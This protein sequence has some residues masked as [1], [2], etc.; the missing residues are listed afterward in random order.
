MARNALEEPIPELTDSE[1]LTL[2]CDGEEAEQT[3]HRLPPGCGRSPRLPANCRIACRCGTFPTSASICTR[4]QHEQPHRYRIRH[5]TAYTYASDVVHSHQLLH[6]VPRP[7][8]YQQC[9]EHRIDISPAA[10]RRRDDLDAFA[11]R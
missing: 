3:R 10:Y 9:L 8:P 11:I 4:S 1:L 7:A 2:E 6:L 5:E